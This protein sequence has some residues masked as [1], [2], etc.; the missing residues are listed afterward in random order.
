M[1]TSRVFG[2]VLV[3]C[4]SWWSSAEAQTSFRRGWLDVNF[5]V[6]A[7][8]DG[9]FEMEASAVDAAGET[10]RARAVHRLPRGGSFDVGGGAM[11]TPVFGLGVSLTGTAHHGEVDLSVSV[12]HPLFFNAFASDSSTTDRALLRSEGGFSIQAMVVVADQGS[13]RVRVFGGPTYFRVEQEGV[14]RIRYVQTF[15]IFVPTNSVRIAEYEAA[16]VDGAGWGGHVGGDVTYFFSRS[17]GVGAIVRYTGGSVEIEN[18]LGTG[19][20]AVATGG[21]QFA[22]GARFRF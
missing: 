11:I 2:V 7:A 10:E 8:R 15:G 16:K 21:L 17:V 5:G 6:A 14:S 1:R 20:V 12:P 19:T 18:T 22:G 13:L 3:L 9:S 4:V